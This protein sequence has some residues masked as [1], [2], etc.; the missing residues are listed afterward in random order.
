MSLQ[1]FLEYTVM[2]TLCENKQKNPSGQCH[3]ASDISEM[4]SKESLKIDINV[5]GGHSLKGNEKQ[6]SH[7]FIPL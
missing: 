3:G 7:F 4:C 5:S 2:C 1:L 6:K